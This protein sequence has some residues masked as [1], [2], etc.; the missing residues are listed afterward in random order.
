M[1]NQSIP[2]WVIYNLCLTCVELVPFPCESYD[3]VCGESTHA[4]QAGSTFGLTWNALG[5]SMTR[6]Q[7][8]DA[9]I[10]K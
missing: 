9:A 2:V 10:Q 5:T 7:L 1:G 8:T 6:H 4:I 3:V